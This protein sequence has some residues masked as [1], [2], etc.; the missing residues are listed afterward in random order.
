MSTIVKKKRINKNSEEDTRRKIGIGKRIREI[1]EGQKS[2]YYHDR[3]PSQEEF[4]EIL[5]IE[6]NKLSRIEG[7]AQDVPISVLILLSKISGKSME[8]ILLEE[9]TPENEKYDKTIYEKSLLINSIIND[10][11]K[12]TISEIEKILKN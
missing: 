2:R 10:S 3:K 12:H 5:E 1:R 8:W 11:C 9:E 6:R 7:G 4:A